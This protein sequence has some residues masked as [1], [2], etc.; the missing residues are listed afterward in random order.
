[1]DVTASATYRYNDRQP[2]TFAASTSRFQ[3]T[4]LLS[5]MPWLEKYHPSGTVEARFGGSGNPA[6]PDGIRLKGDV[7]LENF[8]VRPVDQIGRWEMVA[9]QLT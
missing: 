6:E 1:L 7:A 3:V 5:V 4:H 2:L 8:S 9:G